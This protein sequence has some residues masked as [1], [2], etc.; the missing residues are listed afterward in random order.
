MTKREVTANALRFSSGEIS[1]SDPQST[2]SPATEY[3]VSLLAR[4]AGAI[5]HWYWGQQTVHDIAGMNVSAKIPIDFNH[6]TSEVIGYLDNFENTPEGLL[7]TGKLV[8]FSDDDR[9]SDIARKS[10]AGIPWQ[11]SINFGGDGIKVESVPDGESVTVNSRE[12]SGPATIIR[13]WPLR[14]VAITPYGADGETESIVLSEEGNNILV[15]FFEMETNMSDDQQSVAVA[16]EAIEAEATEQAVDEVISDDAAP[17]E[18]ETQEV[19]EALE[20]Q[21]APENADVQLSQ[22]SGQRYIELF[23]DQG[24][25]W[26]VE[27]KSIEECYELHISSLVARTEL[28][29]NEVSQ[30]RAIERGEETPVSFSHP[31][32]LPKEDDELSLRAKELKKAGVGSDFVA[33]QAARIEQQLSR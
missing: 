9:A 4:S 23:G 25:V 11:A 8:S 18:T 10:K 22:S 32:A 21:D 5:E 27:G 12:F 13:S 16:E 17:V 28:L 33:T 7:A 3:E 30:L 14:G 1:V 29:E 26:F 2:D 20:E 6:D 15:D 24:A 19:A 31:D